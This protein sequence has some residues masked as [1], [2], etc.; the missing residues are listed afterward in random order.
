[1]V[2]LFAY[3]APNCLQA[4]KEADK[5]AQIKIV[6]FDEQD[7]TLQGIIDGHIHGTVSQQPFEYGRE[8]VRVLAALARN[9]PSVIPPDKFLEVS[10][11]LVRRANVQDFWAKLKRLKGLKNEG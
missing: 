11:V 8:S 5:L 4:V 9:D 1:M 7:A 10:A 3:N 6:S 2:G